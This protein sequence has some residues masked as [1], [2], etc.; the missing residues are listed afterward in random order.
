MNWKLKHF[1]T[2]GR[3]RCCVFSLGTEGLW[4]LNGW[5]DA[6]HCCIKFIIQMRKRLTRFR[7]SAQVTSRTFD[8]HWWL[9]CHLLFVILCYIRSIKMMKLER[10]RNKRSQWKLLFICRSWKGLIKVSIV[11]K[12]RKRCILSDM[13]LN[14]FIRN[15]LNQIQR[16][17][18]NIKA[19]VEH[20][21][22]FKKNKLL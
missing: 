15:E 14:L 18:I 21:Y 5:V 8:R 2:I 19:Y 20:L 11:F 9:F 17:W 6:K 22:Y 13:P 12:T 10:L 4:S 3:E 16:L 1:Q 7:L